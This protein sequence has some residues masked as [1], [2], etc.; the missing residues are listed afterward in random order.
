MER[1]NETSLLKIDEIVA[2]HRNEPGPVIVMLHEVQDSLGYVPFEAILK[3]AE[4]TG[5]SPADVLGV[6]EFYAGF[7]T[8]PKGKHI[9]NVCLGTACYVKGSIKLAEE[10]VKVTGAEL[11]S[12]SADGLFSVDATR[13]VGACG[14]APVCIIDGRVIAQCTPKVVNAEIKK[15]IEAEKGAGAA[16]S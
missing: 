10:A 3:I 7:T 13:C 8:A 11:N 1:L 14:L 2:E 16:N 5:K 15:I 6:V 4:A 9:I 12:V